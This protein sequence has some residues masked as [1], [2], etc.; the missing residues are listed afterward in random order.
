MPAP[1]TPVAAAAAA[2]AADEPAAVRSPFV[3][4]ICTL[5]VFVIGEAKG[6]DHLQCQA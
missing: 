4:I 6:K 3:P 1:A 2:P 5:L